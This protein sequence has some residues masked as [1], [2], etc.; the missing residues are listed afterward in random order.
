WG[1][2]PATIPRFLV[3]VLGVLGGAVPC[4]DALNVAGRVQRIERV[5]GLPLQGRLHR[6][7]LVEDT[8]ARLIVYRQQQLVDVARRVVGHAEGGTVA[9]NVEGIGSQPRGGDAEAVRHACVPAQ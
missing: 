6:A 2:L 1:L 3:G 5:A 7:A 4:L 8:V 9:A